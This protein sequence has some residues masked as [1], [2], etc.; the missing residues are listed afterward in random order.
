MRSFGW[1]LVHH[2]WCPS[3]MRKCGR[4]HA[5]RDRVTTAR[6]DGPLET[7]GQGPRS[8]PRGPPA[9]AS[10]LQSPGETHA[11]FK[12]PRPPRPPRRPVRPVRRC[13]VVQT[14]TRALPGAQSHAFSAS[15]FMPA[16]WQDT[17]ESEVLTLGARE[18]VPQDHAK[19]G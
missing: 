11:L 18:S 10:G 15:M 8:Q 14:G 1:A 16:A 3:K 9:Q 19:A 12:P 6:E 2:G 13:A 7:E 5:A 17:Q 4:T